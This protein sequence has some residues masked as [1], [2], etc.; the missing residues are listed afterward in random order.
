MRTVN[1]LY[2]LLGD[3]ITGHDLGDAKVLLPTD[4]EGNSFNEWSGDYGT[5]QWSA[6][7]GEFSGDDGYIY[8]DTVRAIVIWP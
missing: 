8:P 2:K 5:G 3:M 4:E 6:A 1:D 7:D